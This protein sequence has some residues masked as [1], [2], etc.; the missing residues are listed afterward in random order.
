MKRRGLS[1]V[2]DEALLLVSLSTYLQNL[3]SDLEPLPWDLQPCCN[4][5][6]EGQKG[7]ATAQPTQSCDR[8]LLLSLKSLQRL[9]ARSQ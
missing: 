7:P 3:E 5:L 2:S 9:C 6:D 8:K 1:A 4:V